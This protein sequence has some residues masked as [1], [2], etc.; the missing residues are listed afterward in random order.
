MSWDKDL[1]DILTCPKCQGALDITL[2]ENGLICPACKLK[3]PIR[4][5]IPV[6]MVNEA[7]PVD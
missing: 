6:M 1:L 7:E 5:D 4:D 2:E 3:Y